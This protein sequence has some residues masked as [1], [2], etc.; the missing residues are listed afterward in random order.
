VKEFRRRSMPELINSVVR[1]LEEGKNCCRRATTRRACA[2]LAFTSARAWATDVC[3]P[4]ARHAELFIEA[5]VH[6]DWAH[7]CASRSLPRQSKVLSAISVQ[8]LTHVIER[9]NEGP[10]GFLLLARP[11]QDGPHSV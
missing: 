1:S 10:F 11:P 8:I 5:K 9:G 4:I 6:R 3:V 7:R 2:V